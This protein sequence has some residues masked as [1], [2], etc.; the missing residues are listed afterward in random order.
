MCV[1][2]Y[3]YIYYII[4]YYIIYICTIYIYILCIYPINHGCIH[5][6]PPSHGTFG[7]SW[8]VDRHGNRRRGI[9]RA[10]LAGTAF[11]AAGAGLLTLVALIWLLNDRFDGDL[12]ALL[13]F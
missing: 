2:I 9:R 4:L 5:L 1:Y 10:V 6:D 8:L 11:G 7:V 13:L 3:I 12:M